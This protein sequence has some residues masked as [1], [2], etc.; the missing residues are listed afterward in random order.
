MN[1][2]QYDLVSHVCG[3]ALKTKN[4]SQTKTPEVRIMTRNLMTLA[5]QTMSMFRSSTSRPRRQ[6]SSI[7]LESLEGR[8]SLSAFGG[9]TSASAVVQADLVSL[10][11][12]VPA[13]VS[14]TPAA[15]Q[16]NHIGTPSAIQGK[17]IGT[18]AII[19]IL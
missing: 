14:V 16:G 6:P 10:R 5:S 12:H 13:D 7:C 9:T 19:A 2:D 3:T 8:L 17:H 15:I 4:Q 11:K 18:P 1:L